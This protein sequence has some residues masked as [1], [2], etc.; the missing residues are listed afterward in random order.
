[1]FHRFLMLVSFNWEDLV[2]TQLL[3]LN[4]HSWP[5]Q[6]S[7]CTS[8]VGVAIEICGTDLASQT[9]L[10]LCLTRFCL[11]VNWK[12]GIN[13]WMQPYDPGWMLLCITLRTWNIASVNHRTK[14]VIKPGLSQCSWRLFWFVCQWYRAVACSSV[15]IFLK[16]ALYSKI[17]L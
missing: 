7:F 11:W 12:D 5:H 9:P 10:Q 14:P 1:M 2:F 3:L 13:L 17:W 4:K 15:N 16:D 6:G 8:L